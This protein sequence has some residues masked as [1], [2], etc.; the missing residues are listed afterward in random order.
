MDE[1]YAAVDVLGKGLIIFSAL[2]TKVVLQWR[3]GICPQAVA[4]MQASL[5]SSKMRLRR[6]RGRYTWYARVMFSV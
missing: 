2:V 5:M 6:S 3:L 4:H 1:R